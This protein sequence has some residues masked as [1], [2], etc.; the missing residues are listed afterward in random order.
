L[1]GRTTGAEC[2]RA[3]GARAPERTRIEG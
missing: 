2:D 3:S 1:S